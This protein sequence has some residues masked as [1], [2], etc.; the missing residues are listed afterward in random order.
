MARE[1]YSDLDVNGNKVINVA[2]PVA[3]TDAAN[4]QYVLDN[5]GGSTSS[6]VTFVVGD[7]TAIATGVKKAY[8]SC[9]RTGNITAWKI[10]SDVSTTSSIQVLKA[11]T[12]R[13][14]AL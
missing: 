10:I 2:T 1:V 9:P 6:K 7:D 13:H 8:V 5:A 12:P 14:S 4:K 3:A 11:T